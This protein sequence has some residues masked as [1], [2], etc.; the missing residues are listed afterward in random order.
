MASRRKQARAAKRPV[1]PLLN[2]HR[3]ARYTLVAVGAVAFG[4]ALI[5]LA[6]N[7][8]E[9]IHPSARNNQVASPASKPIT[10]PVTAPSPA[11]IHFS[12]VAADTGL[13]FHHSAGHSDSYLAPEIL[14]P[15]VTIFDADGD[16]RDDVLFAN[17][18]SDLA[19][20]GKDKS[21]TGSRLFRNVGGRFTDVTKDSGI[22]LD[23]YAVSAIAFDIDGD[24][25]RDVIFATTAGL[26]AFTNDGHGRFREETRSRGLAIT[27]WTSVLAP[28]DLDDDGD[29]DL[30][31]GRYFD[32]S[33]ARDAK[34][35]CRPDGAH[36]DYCGPGMYAGTTPVILL[37]DGRG[38][39]TDA[40]QRSNL[41][42]GATKALGVLTVDLDG[43]GRM[44]VIVANDEVRTQ[45]FL[46]RGDGTLTDDAVALGFAGTEGGSAFSGMGIDGTFQSPGGDFTLAIGTFYG[47]PIAAYA[48]AA[49]GRP[50]LA[51][52]TPL[53]LRQPSLSFVK[54]GLR[55][56][57]A[58]ADG[59]DDLLVANGAITHE[60][61]TNGVA[62][63]QPIQVFAG[64]PSRF[65][66]VSK[67]ALGALAEKRLLGRAVA[68]LDFDGDGDLDAVVTEND[69]DALLLENRSERRGHFIGLRLIG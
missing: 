66:E 61:R 35:D 3:R 31:V 56:F 64:T 14:G 17:G 29:L 55:F 28:L 20:P 39:F 50:F 68:T 41:P 47:E 22:G 46:N 36:R 27:G 9:V 24:G 65:V 44:D 2:R 16:G 7:A 25:D 54:F 52:G 23:A 26:R 42:R 18:N 67:N 12:E 63:R 8:S 21:K 1:K 15:G 30:F 33:A 40:S 51:R 34:L 48:R 6:T 4:G 69:G 11:S 32:W 38:H 58:D 45:V 37:N 60:E 62:F 10:V 59:L 13:R 49:L 53:G 43:D 19:G 5:W 57:D